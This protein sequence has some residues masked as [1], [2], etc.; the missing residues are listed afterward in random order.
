MKSN[1]ATAVQVLV[2]GTATKTPFPPT[3][4]VATKYGPG[5]INRGHTGLMDGKNLRDVIVHQ[6]E[7]WQ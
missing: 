3:G 1:M 4:L 2:M 5:E 6:H 7:E